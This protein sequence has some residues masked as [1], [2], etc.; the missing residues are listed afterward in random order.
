ME[1]EA[2]V[3]IVQA[4][5]MPGSILLI[6]RAEREGDSWSGHWSL[7]GGRRD[8]S[9]ADLLDTALRELAEECGIQLDREHVAATLPPTI[10]RRRVGPYLLVAPFLFQVD[11]ELPTTLDRREAV[12]SIWMPLSTLL[13]PERH[14]LRAAPGRPSSMLFPCI[15]LDGPPLWGFTY[16]LLTDWLALTCKGEAGFKAA[17]AVLDFLREHGLPAE[18]QWRQ[19]E[20]A[21]VAFVRGAI[22]A[23]AVLEQFARPGA[24]VAAL[25]CLEVGEDQIRILGPEFEEYVITSDTSGSRYT[26]PA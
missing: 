25:N 11:R 18:R 23:A 10:A 26:P 21:K 22:P 7:P 12:G 3:A 2:A 17:S 16:R 6:R 14:V 24:H 13:D 8:P 15:E 1:P 20:G 5:P 4:G 19:V 9:D